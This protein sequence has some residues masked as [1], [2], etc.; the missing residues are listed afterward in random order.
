M[1]RSAALVAAGGVAG[2][3]GA[4]LW[5]RRRVAG[6]R[7][8]ERGTERNAVAARP[9]LNPAQVMRGDDAATVAERDDKELMEELRP[10][11]E[12]VARQHGAREVTLWRHR[13][14]ERTGYDIVAWSL[15]GPPPAAATWGEPPERA[16]V[17]WSATEQM[18]GFERRDNEPMLAICPVKFTSGEA[19]GAIV[20]RADGKFL[21]ARDALRDWLPRQAAQVGRLVSL[22]TT[23]NEVA[24]QSRFTRALLRIASDLQRTHEPVEL[25]RL[26]CDYACDVTG[27]DFAALVRWDPSSR[28]GRVLSSSSGAPLL[29]REGALDATSLVGTACVQATAHFW[30]DARWLADRGGVLREGDAGCTAGSFAVL[31]MARG[32]DAIGALVIGALRTG[33]LRA[34]EI[35]N[36]SVL[37]ALAMNALETA[38]ELAET[39]RRSRTDALTGVW[40][41]RHFDEQL[42]R[43]L[44]EVDR[45]EQPCALIICDI[46]FFKKVNDTHGHDA[47]DVVLMQVADVLRAGVRTVDVCAR[48]GG[49]EFALLLPQT[50][51]EGAVELAERL[52]E[53]VAALAVSH[54][55]VTMRVTVSL[56]VSTYAPGAPGK[57]LLFKRADERL[58]EAKRGGRNRVVS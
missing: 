36:G 1:W 10:F 6:E 28:A 4:W 20:L 26:L 58:Y 27:A 54:A 24:R 2:A 42:E 46:D 39:S 13:G 18:V 11:L 14:G 43:V 5:M 34:L 22:F 41:R 3:V 37:S 45:F 52:R 23:R 30:E 35:R 29:L 16:L 51:V 38:W 17:E 32:G 49:E 56:G 48:L 9:P 57:A 44:N 7:L 50:S 19:V 47:G 12:D 21:T 33:A 25:E 53:R 31:P 8:T 40:N 15:D 55:G